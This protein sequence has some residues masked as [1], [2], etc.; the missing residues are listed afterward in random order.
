[1]ERILPGLRSTTANERRRSLW[2]WASRIL[3]LALLAAILGR[4][5]RAE[6]V[7][8]GGAVVRW[9]AGLERL[10]RRAESVLPA[11][12]AEVDRR[13]GWTHQGPVADVVIVRGFDRM[14]AEAR[15]RV[16]R[17]AV[18]VTVASRSLIVIR[19]D[20]L[21][22]GFGGSLAQVIRHE[23]VHLAWGRYAGP[24][25]RALPLWAEEGLAEEIGG[26]ISL[27]AGAALDLA[28]AFGR[29]LDFE[30]LE[31]R[32]PQDP[33]GADLAYKQSRSWI[34]FAVHHTG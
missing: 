29:L 28:V 8:A 33:R 27:D 13:L 22:A 11:I 26:G 9:D 30:S 34:Q 3:G 5:A 21:S 2:F 25:R 19:S 18:G 16:P 10:G 12:R 4:A 32:F 20:L 23:W 31:T 14:C 7:V 17:W 24:R 6:E 15:A 1:M